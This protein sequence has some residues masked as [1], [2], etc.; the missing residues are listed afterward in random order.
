MLKE[1]LDQNPYVVWDRHIN[2]FAERADAPSPEEIISGISEGT[3]GLVVCPDARSAIRIL[4]AL[5]I[6][7]DNIRQIVA[8]FVRD[9]TPV[10]TILEGIPDCAIL[11]GFDGVRNIGLFA[12]M[13]EFSLEPDKRAVTLEDIPADIKELLVLHD[14][15]ICL[16]SVVSRSHL[17]NAFGKQ[18]LAP[19]SNAVR[20]ELASV[21]GH[22]EDLEFLPDDFPAWRR[23]CLAA[24]NSAINPLLAEDINNIDMARKA[25]YEEKS[26]VPE[27]VR[28]RPLWLD[29]FKQQADKLKAEGVKFEGVLESDGLAKILYELG[30]EYGMESMME[31]VNAG[32]PAEDI[33]LSTFGSRP[34]SS[35]ADQQQ[36]FDRLIAMAKK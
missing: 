6:V 12:D 26:R 19:L 24:V 9:K 2:D 18:K 16:D 32:V 13:F 25:I 30:E 11:I 14:N 35:P 17:P 27:L 1:H 4:C 31:A 23:K 7:P 36:A 28:Y 34:S 29:V 5:D 10:D 3:T 8:V 20:K 22:V 21:L 15:G 33:V